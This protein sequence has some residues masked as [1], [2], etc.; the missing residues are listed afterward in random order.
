[1]TNDT[2]KTPEQP[3]IRELTKE[4]MLMV[5]GGRGQS[6]SGGGGGGWS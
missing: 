1:M 3:A 4:E 5:S 6:E 2:K